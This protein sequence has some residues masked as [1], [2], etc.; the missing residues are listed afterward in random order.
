MTDMT[1]ESKII[2]LSLRNRKID[3]IKEIVSAYY[4]QQITDYDRKSRNR[5]VIKLKYTT[6]WL[7]LKNVKIPLTELGKLFNYDHATII[8][9]NKQI[10]NYLFFD[11]DLKK[12][13]SEL[14]ALIEHRLTVVEGKLNLNEDYHYFNLNDCLV[15]KHGLGKAIVFTGY[16]EEEVYRALNIL[17]VSEKL[18]QFNNTNM[19]LIKRNENKQTNINNDNL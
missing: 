10:N 1:E 3:F 13:L 16:T 4:K 9:A 12:E 11:T 15:A 2:D 14:T 19:Y 5:E 17:G 6:I 7:V 18:I 8:H